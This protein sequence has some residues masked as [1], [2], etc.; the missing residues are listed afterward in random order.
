MNYQID[1]DT[2]HGVIRATITTTVLTH[3]LA[4]ECYRSVALAASRG[5]Q[6]AAIWDLSQV[7][8]TTVSSDQVRGRARRAP[9]VPAGRTRVVVAKE[10][11][12]Y[13]FCRMIELSR[14]PMGGE[15]QVVRSLE[16]A[17]EI[18]GVRPEDFTERLYPKDLAA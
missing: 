10:P 8:S 4:E 5:G 1:L 3:E 12:I 7:T 14:D 18:V 17:Y 16:E 11:V 2:K 6:Y 13:G 15:L 9:A